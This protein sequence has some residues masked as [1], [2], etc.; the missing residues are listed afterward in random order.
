[1]DRN[2]FDVLIYNSADL[3]VA[4]VVG[5]S[6]RRSGG[7]NSAEKRVMTALSRINMDYDVGIFPAGKYKVGDVILKQDE[8]V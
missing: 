1:M 2:R 4:S 3:K 6:M 7:F 8:E 5:A